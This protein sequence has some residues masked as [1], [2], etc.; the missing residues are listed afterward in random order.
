L[1]NRSRDAERS[2][3]SRNRSRSRDKSRGRSWRRSRQSRSR[4]QRSRCR[5]R[6]R[7]DTRSIKERSRSKSRPAQS[8]SKQRRSRSRGWRSSRSRSRGGRNSRSRSNRSESSGH[9]KDMVEEKVQSLRNN[10]PP[11]SAYQDPYENLKIRGSSSRGPAS[12]DDVGSVRQQHGADGDQQRTGVRPSNRRPRLVQCSS[13]FKE[14]EGSTYN[15]LQKNFYQ[16][17]DCQNS[18]CLVCSAVDVTISHFYGQGGAPTDSRTCPLYGSLPLSADAVRGSNLT[19]VLG[20]VPAR[21]GDAK[22]HTAGVSD[23][24]KNWKGQGKE[25]KP[26]LEPKLNQIFLHKLRGYPLWPVRITGFTQDRRPQL[27]YLVTGEIGVA[28]EDCSD[29]SPFDAEKL[30]KRPRKTLAV[31]L[32]KAFQEASE[33]TSGVHSN[34]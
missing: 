18:M 33:E 24:R 6:R 29:L 3:S 8:R 25:N 10:G 7:K 14:G 19:E 2:R 17:E 4:R 11:A 26:R 20:K 5:S 15:S 31:N 13:C 32:K 28:H 12:P 23:V 22:A 34:E 27:L 30:H 9:E 16:C 21:R 1:R